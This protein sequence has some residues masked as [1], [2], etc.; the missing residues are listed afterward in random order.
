MAEPD[1]ESLDYGVERNVP[2]QIGVGFVHGRRLYY[3]SR[4]T[5]GV[6]WETSAKGRFGSPSD[7]RSLA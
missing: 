4:E 3:G 2:C 1:G 5:P 7:L 6:L